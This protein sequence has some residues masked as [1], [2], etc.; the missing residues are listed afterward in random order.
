MRV[1]TKAIMRQ[2]RWRLDR[3]LHH[4]VYFVFY[5]PY[6][7]TVARALPLIPRL[8]R[9]RLL[10]AALEMAVARYHAKMLSAGDARK[11]LTLKQDIR[12]VS[13]KNRRIVPYRYA[14]RIVFQAPDQIAVMDCPCKAAYGGDTPEKCC[15][16]VGRPVSDFWIEHCQKYHA[17]RISQARAL[18]IITAYRQRGYVTQAFFK[19]ATGGGT[20]VICNCHPNDCA[21]LQANRHL[22]TVD[23]HLCMT[24]VAGYRV[25]Q[26]PDRCTACGACAE[27]CHFD[28]VHVAGG[29]WHYDQTA[30]MGCELCVEHCPNGALELVL[31]PEKPR[32]L[33]MDG[34]G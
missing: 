32:P 12:H 33:D 22:R 5:A 11:I 16:A 24:A 26:A 18:A 8:R 20:G 21:A 34:L 7:K 23:P 4:Y 30:C 2:H 3:F 25:V 31:D 27:Q 6:V 9:S 13:V 14:T 19:V 17:E 1:S 28:A 10:R 15:I 29:R